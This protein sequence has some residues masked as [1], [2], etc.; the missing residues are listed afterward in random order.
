[1]TPQRKAAESGAVAEAPKRARGRRVKPKNAA[2]SA[3]YDPTYARRR[4]DF[5]GRMYRG[6]AVYCRLTCALA[7]A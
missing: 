7:D 2:E 1:M 4:C 3:Y 6:P 5:C